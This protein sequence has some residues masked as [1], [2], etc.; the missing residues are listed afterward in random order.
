VRSEV[1]YSATDLF[2][3]DYKPRPSFPQCLKKPTGN[4]DAEPQIFNDVHHPLVID[5]IFGSQF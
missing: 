3:T 2:E 5:P 1:P 4:A